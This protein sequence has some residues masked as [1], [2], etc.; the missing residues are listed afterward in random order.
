MAA[1]AAAIVTNGRVVLAHSP[2]KNI[3]DGLTTD[4]IMLIEIYAKST[5]LTV[6]VCVCI[7]CSSLC[8]P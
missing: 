2:E 5:Q 4:D 6:Q 3:V 1:G 8:S 7:L